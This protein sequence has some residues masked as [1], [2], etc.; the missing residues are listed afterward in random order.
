MP[1]QISEEEKILYQHEIKASQDKIEEIKKKEEQ[2]LLLIKDKPEEGP[3][4][5]LVLA[6]EMLNLA[7]CYFEIGAASKTLLN[8]KNEEILNEG[9]KTIYKCLIYLENVVTNFIDAPFSEYEEKLSKISSFDAAQRYNLAEKTGKTIDLLKSAYGDNTKW[10]WSFVDIDGRFATVAKN[11]LDLKKAVSNTDPR[12]PDYEPTV[13]HLEMIKKLLNH[14][15]SRYREKYEAST[16]AED[17]QN[18]IS[19]LRALFRIHT[20]M[21]DKDES[22]AIKKKYEIWT[23]K[24]KTDIK[25]K[26]VHGH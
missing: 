25:S 20:L 4:T 9:R 15:A 14:A 26:K 18:A 5:G 19:Y 22:A 12:S 13:Y 16:S 24:L 6:E 7:E 8:S 3:L 10:K 23:A 11:L 21:G 1:K 2:L 17:F